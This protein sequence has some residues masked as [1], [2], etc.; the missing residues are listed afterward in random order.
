MYH[1]SLQVAVLD[2]C[3]SSEQGRVHAPKSQCSLLLQT[4]K[5]LD[6]RPSG[7]NLLAHAVCAYISAYC[8]YLFQR[9]HASIDCKCKCVHVHGCDEGMRSPRMR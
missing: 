8:V 1:D 9:I 7:V 6:T 4:S 5:A 2:F 3:S